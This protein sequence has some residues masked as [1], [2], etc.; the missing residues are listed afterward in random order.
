MKQ[1]TCLEQTT[2]LRKQAINS[3]RG[4]Q[5]NQ[6]TAMLFNARVEGKKIKSESLSR[7]DK[8]GEPQSKSSDSKGKLRGMGS[9]EKGDCP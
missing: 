7:Y 8:D 2:S 3:L 5:Y 1:A 9:D 4:G 6:R